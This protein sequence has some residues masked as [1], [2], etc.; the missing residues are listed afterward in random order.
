[1]NWEKIF[2]VDKLHIFT[3]L[4]KLSDNTAS[5]ISSSNRQLTNVYKVLDNL[6]IWTRKLTWQTKKL[7]Y[8][9]I[10]YIYI[11]I[12]ID[13]YRPINI[14]YW[15]AWNIAFHLKK[16]GVYVYKYFRI[17]W[18]MRYYQNSIL[19]MLKERQYDL[20]RKMFVYI[21]L[22]L[23][24]GWPI[25]GDTSYVQQY[26]FTHLGNFPKHRYRCGHE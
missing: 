19:K 22:G 14:K 12:C 11:T 9:C 21:D 8:A 23:L 10:A 25:R 4:Q 16:D 7:T 24:Q 18:K 20:N 2:I 5:I 13:R 15:A 3:R 26:V 1:M 17:L 6:K